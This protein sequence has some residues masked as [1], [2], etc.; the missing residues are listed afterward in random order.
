MSRVKHYLCCLAAIVTLVPAAALLGFGGPVSSD[1][2][3][4][5]EA[6]GTDEVTFFRGSRAEGT[7]SGLAHP[8][9]AFTGTWSEK[10]TGFRG[11]GVQTWEF[12][13]GTLTWSMDSV[14]DH[15]TLISVGTFVVIDGTGMFEGASGSADYTRQGLGGGMGEIV[16]D[17][18]ISLGRS[19]ATVGSVQH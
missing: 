12:S 10:V 1:Q 5:L 15:E 19:Q 7:S 4:P 9:G 16:L 14:F 3:V 11:S 13:G 8:G 17:G 18:Q 6:S 2:G